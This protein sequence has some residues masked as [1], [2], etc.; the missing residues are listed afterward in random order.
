[1]NNKGFHLSVS[2]I[3][4]KKND[5]VIAKSAYNS[6]SEIKDK[7]NGKT[8]NYTSKNREKII[9]LVDEN[10]VESTKVVEKNLV[11]TTLIT[12]MIAG[13]LK[14][15]RSDFWNQI[16]LIETR[17]NAQYG[18]EIDVM[19]PDGVS[20]SKYIELAEKF[21]QR[22]SD[23]YNVLVDV[24]IHRPHTHIQLKDNDQVAELTT[25]N[26]HAHILLSS[27]EI[28][29]E[30][31]SSYSLSSRKNWLQWSTTD[32]LIKGLNGRGEELKYIRKLWADLSNEIL[33]ESKHISEKSYREQGINLLPKMKLGKTLYRDI[34]NNKSSVIQDYNEL[35]NDLNNYIKSKDLEIDYNDDG[36][37]DLEPNIQEFKGIKVEYRK[38]K[39][40]ASI[41]LSNIKIV[42][43]K[44][45]FKNDIDFNS[46]IDSFMESTDGIGKKK[47]TERAT[48]LSTA[49]GLY[50]RLNKQAQNSIIIQNNLAGFK[51]NSEY[52]DTNYDN[53]IL[54][55]EKKLKEISTIN[56]LKSIEKIMKMLDRF[57]KDDTLQKTS[58]VQELKDSLENI[59]KIREKNTKI[60][61]EIV[62]INQEIIGKHKELYALK[63]PFDKLLKDVQK[64]IEKLSSIKNKKSVLALDWREAFDDLVDIK[65]TDNKNTYDK[66]ARLS[67]FNT[68]KL[69]V[70]T[71]SLIDLQQTKAVD[72]DEK[73]KQQ[74]DFLLRDIKAFRADNVAEQKELLQQINTSKKTYERYS[75]L[76]NDRQKFLDESNPI[77][78]QSRELLDEI[79]DTKTNQLSVE[80]LSNWRDKAAA[81]QA[82]S[83]RDKELAELEDKKRIERENEVKRLLVEREIATKKEVEIKNFTDRRVVLA[84]R[85]NNKVSK[86]DFK[87]IDAP[88]LLIDYA[89]ILVK[90]IFVLHALSITDNFTELQ[91]KLRDKEVERVKSIVDGAAK[92]F[93]KELDKLPDDKQKIEVLDKL[94]ERFLQAPGIIIND[95]DI[96]QLLDKK[97]LTVESEIINKNRSYPSMRP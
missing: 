18:T 96:T 32:R 66:K 69:S 6:G 65:V 8:H 2:A 45:E 57:S 85:V 86:L 89:E 11:Y 71:H 30:N 4:K 40:Y 20:K 81:L 3:S 19:F 77:I 36:R 54:I 52:L 29:A 56:Q 51:N 90:N 39:P 10:G 53:K 68:E 12:P 58:A 9:N 75:K 25:N 95:G 33:P 1:M 38:R 50:E 31:N 61:K 84:D 41:D 91:E 16:E 55:L 43:P 42:M 73:T 35:V 94:K 34:L 62:P 46:L 17:K 79:I 97:T 60:L 13:D 70:F 21:S 37:I 26:F 80:K 48:I 72:I 24:S 88:S 67:E 28:M 78:N 22:L 74:A 63:K 7:K 83:I 64:E 76:Y 93:I 14:V 92:D 49:N 27:R 59:E 82:Q 87:S 15:N 23:R 44:S 47:K 5:S